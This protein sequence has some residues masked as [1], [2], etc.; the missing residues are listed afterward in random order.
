MIPPSL[1]LEGYRRGVFPM[2]MP[3]G[4]VQWF[5][6]DPRGIIPLDTFRISRR[7]ARV[8]RRGLGDAVYALNSALALG[9]P[10]PQDRFA[11][12]YHG[13][14]YSFGY[15]A[16]PDLSERTKVIELLKP[17]S[18]GVTLSENFMLVPEQST[19]ALV[20]H[21]PKA[22]YFDVKPETEAAAAGLRSLIGFG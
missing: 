2:G 15:P 16:C 11:A 6:P 4:S 12:R 3:D 21:H 18:I 5:S 20:A 13:R 7:L 22:K 19:D 17:E 1:L 8:V 10:T 14:R 9:P